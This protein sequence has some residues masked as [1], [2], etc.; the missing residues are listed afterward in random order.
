MEEVGAQGSRKG[1]QS[2][3]KIDTGAAKGPTQTRFRDPPSLLQH[4]RS[5]FEVVFDEKND[6][7]LD[8]LVHCIPGPENP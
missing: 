8:A 2:E 7:K 3:A 1:A 5:S 6:K 4:V